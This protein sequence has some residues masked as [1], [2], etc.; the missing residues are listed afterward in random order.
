MKKVI[1]KIFICLIITTLHAQS[2]SIQ[3]LKCYGGTQ[4]DNGMSV[5]QTTD[6]GYIVI[7]NT[8]SN[9]GDVTDAPGYVDFWILKLNSTGAIQW[10][11]T[12]G[13]VNTDSAYD[14]EQTSDGGYVFIGTVGNSDGDVVGSFGS[15]IWVVKLNSTGTIT[16]QKTLGGTYEEVGYC[17]KQTADNG[18]I[19]A[20]SSNS[21]DGGVTGNHGFID[22]W[23]IKLDSAGA[24]QWQKSYG[25]T[26][27]DEAYS[28]KQTSDGG[29]IVAA[30]TG[31]N[32]GNVTNFHGF[33]D[34]WI[35][36][37]NSSGNL[38]WQK[39]IGGS[40]QDRIDKIELTNDGGY[41]L[42]GGTG[43]NN[44]D[45]SGQHGGYEA[46]IVKMNSS[47]TIQW[48]KT[49]GGTSDDVAKSIIQTTDGGYVAVGN[50]VSNDGDVIGNHINGDGW[51]F[52]LNSSGIIQWQKYF[53]GTGIDTMNNI[54]QTTDG[55][56][57]LTGTS[58][59]S[60]IDGATN[61]GSDDL[62]VTKLTPENLSIDDFNN[63]K[64]NIYPNP[65]EEILQINSNNN[66]LK[67][68][69]ILDLNGRL[70]YESF[71]GN[72]N[73]NAS[74]LQSGV[75]MIELLFDNDLVA[76]QKIIKK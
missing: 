20:G 76:K 48:Q 16:W 17:I 52:K 32:N 64:I 58:G 42:A 75:Y 9:D 4:I 34:A 25:G 68:I 14:I 63:P 53:G 2:P 51:L 44:G 3:W 26:E 18:Y 74:K 27:F 43:S 56:F 66:Q 8:Y 38:V 29:Y 62:I 12:L 19:I 15:Q 35:L 49:I 7:G 69:K 13:S 73:I 72:L 6:G 70:I 65:V 10:Q 21:S 54:R 46:W 45:I 30:Y 24:V 37:L 67:S 40:G 39:T 31:S 5:K 59:S 11:K 71:S 47:G 1:L 41:I 57:I 50:T 36:K 61:H 60:T 23:I 28:I 55:G 33:Y 22:A